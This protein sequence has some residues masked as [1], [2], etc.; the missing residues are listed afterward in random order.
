MPIFPKDHLI[1]QRERFLQTVQLLGDHDVA[2]AHS[3]A[4]WSS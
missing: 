2:C 1:H 3:G 4:C